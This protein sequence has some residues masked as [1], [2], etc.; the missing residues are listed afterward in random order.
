[1]VMRAYMQGTTENMWVMKENKLEMKEYMKEKK[2]Y[3][4]VTME[5]T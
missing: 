4:Q 1:M 5:N 2:D 3:M